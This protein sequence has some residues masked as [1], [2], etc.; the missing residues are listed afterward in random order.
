VFFCVLGTRKLVR[1]FVWNGLGANRLEK[2]AAHA[3]AERVAQS[4]DG[5]NVFTIRAYS[6]ILS[7]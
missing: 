4:F 2:E 6:E 1:A 7:S 5:V 3:L